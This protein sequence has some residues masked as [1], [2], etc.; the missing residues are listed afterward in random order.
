MLILRCICWPRSR[1]RI[2]Y[3]SALDVRAA[4]SFAAAISGAPAVDLSGGGEKRVLR[5]YL[6]A[7]GGR[8]GEGLWCELSIERTVE[9]GGGAVEASRFSPMECGK[10]TIGTTEDLS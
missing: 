10:G 3:T 4:V 1:S 5:Y 7:I 6:G 9:V 2:S 8:L